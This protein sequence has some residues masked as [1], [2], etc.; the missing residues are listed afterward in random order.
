VGDYARCG[1]GLP[2]AKRQSTR[3]TSLEHA[4]ACRVSSKSR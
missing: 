2:V 3:R 1:S 4:Q